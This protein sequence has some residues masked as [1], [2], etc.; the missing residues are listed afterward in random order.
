MTSKEVGKK[1]VALCREGKNEE[2]M[3]SL[4]EKNI[5]SVE[6]MSPPG[7][8]KEVKGLEAC[9]GKSKHWT[10]TM[11]VHSAK[12][13][14]PFPNGD[15]FAVYYNYDVTQK[16]SGKRMK[17]EEVGVYTVKDGKIVHEEFMYEMDM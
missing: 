5:V 1:L 9:L 14:G 13:E 16:D 3:K 7:G 6:A 12:V 4:Y 11:Q 17:L 8:S 15:S 2:A 10:E